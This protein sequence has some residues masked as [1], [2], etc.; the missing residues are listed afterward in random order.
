MLTTRRTTSLQPAPSVSVMLAVALLCVCST[1][2]HAQLFTR[3]VNAFFDDGDGV[4]HV[5]YAH[6]QYDGSP[7][8][9]PTEI[10]DYQRSNPTVAPL[11][12]IP[13]ATAAFYNKNESTS[14][15]VLADSSN[16]IYTYAYQA[17]GTTTTSLLTTLNSA[18]YGNIVAMSGF[19][20]TT[21]VRRGF[22]GEL[23]I[24]VGTSTR[25]LIDIRW[26]RLSPT[27]ILNGIFTYPAGDNI[28]DVAAF[29]SYNSVNGTDYEAVVADT[30]GISGFNYDDSIPYSSYGPQTFVT[31]SVPNVSGFGNYTNPSYPNYVLYTTDS[32]QACTFHFNFYSASTPVCFTDS[33]FTILGG[34]AAEQ[35]G[36][37]VWAFEEEINLVYDTYVTR[38]TGGG[39]PVTLDGPY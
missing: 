33:G 12:I 32:G 17:T 14:Y 30:V 9:P 10:T 20:D 16:N 19:T 29:Y 2:V 4:V 25:R 7:Y 23:H 34:S 13:V 1:T 37:V 8:V 11:S 18:T 21:V 24:L 31:T 38:W 27:P 3:K 28:R 36:T 35:S 26:S 39:S 5:A 6:G 15:F 22:N